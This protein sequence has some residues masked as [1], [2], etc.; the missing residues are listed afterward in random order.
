MFFKKDNKLKFWK[1]FTENKSKIESFIENKNRTDYSIYHL[2]SRK[3]KKVHSE[4]IPELTM[5]DD[6]YVLIISC[7]GISVGIKPVQELAAVAPEIPNWMIKKFRQPTDKVTLNYEGLEL[8]LN[9]LRIS[10]E[11]DMEKEKV[12][13]ILK[14][15]NFKEADIRF[16]SLGFLYLDHI[17]GEFNVMTRVGF[18]DFE[19]LEQDNAELITLVEFRKVIEQNLY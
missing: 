7:D 11:L 8:D 15:C 12:D 4:L 17:V 9:D 10:Y 19:I 14:M 5:E 1:W 2:L 6:N 16:K 3:M 18:I 13:I